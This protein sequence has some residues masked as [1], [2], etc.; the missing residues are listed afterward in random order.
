[1]S[2]EH[3]IDEDMEIQR[4][5]LNIKQLTKNLMYLE[6]KRSFFVWLRKNS[7]AIAFGF[8]MGLAFN[9]HLITWQRGITKLF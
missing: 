4:L 1:M 6:S 2:F 3:K 8:I 9:E 7:T 5:K